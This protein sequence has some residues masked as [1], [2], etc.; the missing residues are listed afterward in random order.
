MDWAES[1][2]YAQAIA[3]T[4]PDGDKVLAQSAGV[5]RFQRRMLNDG[6]KGMVDVGNGKNLYVDRA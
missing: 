1:E 2:T 3:S 4:S 5:A 6:I